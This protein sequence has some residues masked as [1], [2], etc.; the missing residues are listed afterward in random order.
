MT[1]R[2]CR[3]F[4]ARSDSDKSGIAEFRF[5]TRFW[6]W[7]CSMFRGGVEIEIEIEEKYDEVSN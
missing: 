2:S 7:S 1:M 6:S 4:D 3:I 5:W